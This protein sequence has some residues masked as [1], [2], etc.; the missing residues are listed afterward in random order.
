MQ[1]EVAILLKKSTVEAELN[2]KL[3]TQRFHFCRIHVAGT[4]LH[5]CNHVLN[6]IGREHTR[7]EE[8]ERNADQ[9]RQR[10]RK[11]TL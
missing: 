10:P 6:W 4:R 8:D 11:D 3:L 9:N 2:S 5:L 1:Q 7:D